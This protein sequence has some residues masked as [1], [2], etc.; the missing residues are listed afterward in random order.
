MKY[1][2]RKAETP[3]MCSFMHFVQG[4]LRYVIGNGIPVYQHVCFSFSLADNTVR[5]LLSDVI[6]TRQ[7]Q[8]F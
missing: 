2:D 4:M 8:R 7:G 5:N 6:W 1:A 3:I